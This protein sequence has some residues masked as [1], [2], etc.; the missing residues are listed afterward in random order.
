MT[1]SDGLDS[2]TADVVVTAGFCTAIAVGL[3]TLTFPFAHKEVCLPVNQLTGEEAQKIAQSLIWIKKAHTTISGNKA[4]VGAM[5]RSGR[6]EIIGRDTDEWVER[7][8]EARVTEYTDSKTM[9]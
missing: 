1:T 6:R 8:W 7:L 3:T 2:S 9:E 5:G 4:E